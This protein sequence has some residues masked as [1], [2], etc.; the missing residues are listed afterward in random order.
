MLGA[1]EQSLIRIKM[2]VAGY[3]GCGL[4]GA[5]GARAPPY[6]R[7]FLRKPVTPV[8]GMNDYRSVTV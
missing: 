1:S 7:A 6:F 8:P 3:I 4:D 5:T 2:G